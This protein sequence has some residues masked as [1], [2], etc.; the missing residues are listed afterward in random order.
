MKVA[1]KVR[2]VHMQIMT[3]SGNTVA[4]M[5]MMMMMTASISMKLWM[6]LKEL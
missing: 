6:M 2:R 5:M 1:V 4:M 3:S